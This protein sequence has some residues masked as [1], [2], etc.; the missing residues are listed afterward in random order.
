MTDVTTEF[1]RGLETRGHEPRL[2]KVKGTL[3]FDLTNGKRAARWLVEIDKGDISISHKN[4]KADCVVRADRRLFD[5]IAGG[6][7]NAFAAVLRG[8]IGIQ[9]N[10]ELLVMFQRLFPEPP[11]TG[12]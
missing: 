1:F 6:E 12:S 5:G 2:E 10:P 3:R 11:R 7:V 9:G 4:A 8:T